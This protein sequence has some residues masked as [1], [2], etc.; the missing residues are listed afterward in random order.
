MADSSVL[1]EVIVEGKNIKL[2]QR[3]VE[4]L[5]AS[6]NKT[7]KQ[8]K[9]SNNERKKGKKNTDDL[10]RSNENYSR[11][12]KGVAQA[13]S[14]GTKAFSKQRDLIGGGSSGLVG[15]Y[16]T[17][18][19]NLFAA[20][21]LFGA[22]RRA[23]QTEQLEKGLVALGETSG[24]ALKSLS[25]GLKEATGNAISLE[26]AM[27]STVAITSAGLDPS[28]VER[29]GLAAK[30]ASVALGRN[31]EDTLDRVTR[32][33][34]KLEPELLDE[35]GV[36]VRLDE[37]T[38][39]YAASLGKTAGELT[40]FERRLAFQAAVL[41]Q[42]EQKFGD[43]GDSV[44]VS[45]Y[46]NL[47]AAVLDLGKNIATFIS[48][49]LEPLIGFL[50][51][52]PAA[53]LGAIG[54]LSGG[55]LR[56]AALS[57]GTF[58][59]NTNAAEMAQKK[60][61]KALSGQLP[62]LNTTSKTLKKAS[63][64]LKTGSINVNTLTSAIRGQSLSLATNKRF[65]DANTISQ[66][67]YNSRAAASRQITDLLNQAIAR[68]N[69]TL[70]LSAFQYAAAALAS[71]RWSLALKRVKL[72]LS[73]LGKGLLLS[74][75]GLRSWTGAV[76][77]ARLSGL[78]LVGTLK[79][80]GFAFLYAIPFIGAFIAILTVAVDLF[81]GFLNLFR[82]DE[83]IKFNEQLETTTDL[84]DEL[85]PSFSSLEKFANNQSS[86]IQTT[87]QKY[88]VLGNTLKSVKAEI[89]KL[90]ALSGSNDRVLQVLEDVFKKSK[91]LRDL[92]EQE[93]GKKSVRDIPEKERVKVL[94]EVL[95]KQVRITDNARALTEA[96]KATS[97]AFRD[98]RNNLK[99]ETEFT[100]IANAATALATKVADVRKDFTDAK[101]RAEAFRNIFENVD[102]TTLVEF[103]IS[104]E[105][106]S[107]FNDLSKEIAT[108]Q[109]EIALAEEAREKASFNRSKDEVQALRNLSQNRKELNQLVGGQNFLAA[110]IED[111]IEKRTAEIKAVDR[112]LATQK[113]LMSTQ[114]A[115]IKMLKEQND[116]S[117]ASITRITSAENAKIDLQKQSNDI[118]IK[119]LKGRDLSSYS[120]SE[121]VDIKLRIIALGQE[122]LL[123][124]EQKTTAL[125]TQVKVKQG[126]LTKLDTE[127]KYLKAANAELG[128]Q[129]ANLQAIKSIQSDITKSR[130]ELLR[131]RAGQGLT[132]EDEVKL[133]EEAEKTKK[134]AALE[135]FNL[136]V[137]EINL[138]YDL[139]EAKYELMKAEINAAK[140]AGTLSASAAARAS[141][142]LERVDLNASRGAA[143]ARAG[144]EY[145]KVYTEAENEVEM[146]RIKL[147]READQRSVA[148]IY[149]RAEIARASGSEQIAN[150]L[151]EQ[152]IAAEK[153]LIE[154]DIRILKDGG[155]GIAEK[156]VE[157]AEK[158][159]EITKQRLDM[160]SKKVEGLNGIAQA[161]IMGSAKQE[162]ADQ[163]VTTAQ[164]KVDAA[165]SPEEQAAAAA[166]LAAAQSMSI[167]T[168]FGN[169][170]NAINETAAAMA[171]IGPEG[172]LMSTTLTAITSIGS[173]FAS[174]FE[175]MGDSSAS[176]ADKVQAG[177][178]VAMSIMQGFAA[179]SKAAS[180]AKIRGYDNEIAA[181]KKRDG[182]SKESLA[183]IAGLEKKK[184]REQRK[185]FET[186]KKMKI[187]QTI[188]A[189]AQ[190]AIAAYTS[191]AAIPVVGPALG[192][193]AAAMVVAMG[194]KQIS[195]IKSTQFEGGS[196]SPDAGGVSSVSIG[197]RGSSVD[198]AKSQSAGGELGYLRGE[199]G[200]GGAE[201]FTPAFMGSK[202]RA[203]GGSTGYVVGEQGPELFVPDRP[204]TIIPAD[205]TRAARQNPTNVSFNI[206]A[207]DSRG[208]EQVLLEQRGNIIGMLR[209]SA[210]SYGNGFFE[211]VELGLYTPSATGAKRA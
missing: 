106:Q 208:V 141:A 108:V 21:A 31:L 12:Q 39:E 187:A 207:I 133:A 182:K 150:A 98:F 196:G 152:A 134:D 101:G 210:N 186:E 78:A 137:T 36:F 57:F 206:N 73:S 140:E 177:L 14:N 72:G 52:R 5:G 7:S 112:T 74:I 24:I 201:N 110:S 63:L 189:T 200:T 85:T 127:Q 97:E 6:I 124:E 171:A 26:Q 62:K 82:T 15:A 176:M 155:L 32:G 113:V 3:S 172:E 193:A 157:L 4:E 35:I 117:E 76:S 158:L 75:T 48:K 173:A 128:K 71:G 119:E 87:S 129:A 163:A 199:S 211:E 194:A 59:I 1:L 192:A 145:V 81:K 56:Q 107:S 86:S 142:A 64:E 146:A 66:E 46:E 120:L 60:L 123:L 99:V 136:K 80:V 156:E 84:I 51:E 174:A 20:T 144:A 104:R 55:I 23:A 41:E 167:E 90:L 93:T 30:N 42:L 122:N 102:P 162:V 191:L 53:L 91:D 204:G 17:L 203:M 197:S 116:L 96:G 139:L 38:Q 49:F 143:L 54:V 154:R 184:E 25:Q 94:N 109:G 180:D 18:A 58:A 183:K 10:A 160:L 2:V 190:G 68:K 153:A 165:A 45:V 65:L 103:G 44:D 40:N 132:A 159:L 135:N 27:R 209:D 67:V 179:I 151:Q 19:A 69:I 164:T 22:L 88:E 77:F 118:L 79:L 175:V 92:L 9:A 166:E 181:E 37:V 114:D 50:S 170:K 131:A 43:I 16:A 11:G 138:E 33:V 178:S 13:T 47:S 61:G 121:Q 115:Y 8:E 202:S 169:A 70:G 29:F 161:A 105:Q 89:D 100:K 149:R 185:A 205:E 168:A 130:I 95:D 34:T 125:E 147:S 126:A 83:Q 188:I 195:M 111:V 198:L 28:S 148:A